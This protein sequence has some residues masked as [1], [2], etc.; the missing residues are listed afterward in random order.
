MKS[1]QF[2][3][4]LSQLDFLT[5]K[6]K[7]ALSTAL[8]HVQ[9]VDGVLGNLGV[10]NACKHC[11]SKRYYRWGYESGMQRYKCRLCGRTYNALTKTPLAKLHKKVQWLTN[12]EAMLTG[13]SVKTTAQMCGVA[14]STSF[15]WRHRF[16]ELMKTAK[17]SCLKGIVEAD[18]TYF[19]K[20]H[21]GERGLKLARKRGGSATKRG[22]SSEQVPV[23]VARDRNGRTL[24]LQLDSVNKATLTDA[25]KPVLSPDSVLCTDG[26]K[27]YSSVATRCG[28]LH[29]KL[30][31]KAGVKVLE[32]VYHIQNVNAYDSRLKA[33]MQRFHGV[34]TKYLQNY[35]GWRRW[36][37]TRKN[38]APGLFLQRAIYPKNIFPRVMLI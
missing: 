2:K 23:L 15:R 29:K 28:V 24:S 12:A 32:R 1:C 9:P 31:I 18:E 37:D 17:P 20:S 25:L 13:A 21:K 10:V 4:F 26:K 38:P 35:L 11:Q 8:K 5:F 27:S 14:T 34:A 33:W 7:A 16:L 19:L 3:R 30:N 6:Q 22:L 36:I